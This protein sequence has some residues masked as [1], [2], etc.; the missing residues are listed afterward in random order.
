MAEVD[1]AV[2]FIDPAGHADKQK[3]QASVID[4]DQ[5]LTPPAEIRTCHDEKQD[6]SHYDKQP[7]ERFHDL[8]LLHLLP[9]LF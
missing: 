7:S 9:T 1:V 3:R 5:A 8:P 6:G 2:F 4:D